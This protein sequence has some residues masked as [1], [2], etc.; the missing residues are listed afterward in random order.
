MLLDRGLE[1]GREARLVADPFPGADFLQ[2]AVEQ[3]LRLD[4]LRRICFSSSMSSQPRV[5]GMTMRW[6]DSIWARWQRSTL[7]P[8]QR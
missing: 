3:Q 6:P 5:P 4:P 2:L 8:L 7:E 1:E